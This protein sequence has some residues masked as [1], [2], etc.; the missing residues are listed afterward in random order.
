ML[1]SAVCATKALSTLVTSR[2]P[3]ASIDAGTTASPGLAVVA[4]RDVG[5]SARLVGGTTD[6]TGDNDGTNGRFWAENSAES[7]AATTNGSATPSTA[8]AIGK[9]GRATEPRIGTRPP[10]LG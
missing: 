9:M 1:P 10:G 8:R 4:G 7:D 6:A 5:V 2:V 3:V